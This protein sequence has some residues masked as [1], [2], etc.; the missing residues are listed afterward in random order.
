MKVKITINEWSGWNGGSNKAKQKLL[1]INILKRKYRFKD[2]N[3]LWFAF[4]IKKFNKDGVKIK[5]WGD[6]GT[7]KDKKTYNYKIIPSF[8][9]KLGEAKEFKTHTFDWGLTYTIEL[10]K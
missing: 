10:V 4:K 1:P 3:T 6:A 2:K 9:L 7:Y 8:T 5:V